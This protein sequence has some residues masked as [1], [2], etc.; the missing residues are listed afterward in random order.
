MK[1]FFYAEALFTPYK[2]FS[3]NFNKYN[4]INKVSCYVVNATFA[5]EIALKGFLRLN[6]NILHNYDQRL[7]KNHRLDEL[8]DLLL[9]EQQEFILKELS[10]LTTI[11][12]LKQELKIVGNNFSEWRYSF[13][14][15]K[16]NG[17]VN[18]LKTNVFFIKDFLNALNKLL[19]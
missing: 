14:S 3:L 6:Q 7:I 18:N 12:D 11:E 10:L 2:L 5:C 1:V 4:F 9:V 16:A 17:E 19:A 13:Q 15:T 8:F